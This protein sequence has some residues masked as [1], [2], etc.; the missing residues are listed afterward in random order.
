MQ[1]FTRVLLTLVGTALITAIVFADT[2]FSRTTWQTV[3][4]R[5][6]DEIIDAGDPAG[7]SIVFV[8]DFGSDPRLDDQAIVEGAALDRLDWQSDAPAF[9]GDAAGSLTALY[10]SS[11]PAGWFGFRL[12]GS[13]TEEDVFTAGAAFVIRS[14]GFDAD[15]NGFFQISWGLWNS[16][17]T[18]LNRTGSFLSF[19]ADTFE[20]IE[21]DYYPSV[22][23]FFGGPFL[24][25]SAF[26]TE[27]AGDAFANFTSLFDL[28]A[29][30]PLDVPLLA[31]IE[32]RPDVDAFV[33]SVHRIV[34]SGRVVPLNGAVGVAPLQFLAPRNYEVD[35]IGLT[36]W[37][38]GFGGSSPALTATLDFHLLTATSGLVDRPE[39]L[40]TFDDD[41]SDDE[42]SDD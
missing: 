17:T 28:E 6:G 36:L 29:T 26:G 15:P 16:V 35:T 31:V 8:R 23:S 2:N 10:D 39:D 34:D 14:A 1:R 41:E 30:L 9:P 20:L 5:T 19:A 13:F 21:F 33:L 38:D 22:S 40:L 18:G 32:L 3:S 11:M 12:P 4:E 25:P 7:D 37:N 42:S 27:V 24:A